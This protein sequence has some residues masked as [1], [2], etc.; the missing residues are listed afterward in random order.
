MTQIVFTGEFDFSQT[1]LHDLS[2]LGEV[3]QLRLREVLR[4]EMS[5]TYGTWVG[6]SGG[7]APWPQYQLSISFGTSPERLG[8]MTHAVFQEIEAL[9]KFGPTPVDLQKVREMIVRGREGELRRNH[10]WL[11]Q[12][13]VHHRHGWDFSEIPNHDLRL[14][15]VQADR[16]R[17]AAMRYLD[18]ANYVQVSLVPERDGPE[19]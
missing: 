2:A 10:F 9:R 17:E 14:A 7:A 12:M 3:L 4:E 19:R 6:A 18:L 5:G 1:N 16:V 8:E 13:L 11:Q 15:A